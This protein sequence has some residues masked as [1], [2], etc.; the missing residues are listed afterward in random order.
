M[1]I[2]S[3]MSWWAY[4]HIWSDLDTQW[5]K[6]VVLRNM[7]TIRKIKNLVWGY[8]IDQAL[9]RQSKNWVV[10]VERRDYRGRSLRILV[11]SATLI[12]QHYKLSR[13]NIRSV[14]GGVCVCEKRLTNGRRVLADSKY[15]TMVVADF[16]Q[17]RTHPGFNLYWQV[18]QDGN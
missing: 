10:T 8:I 12:G 15:S 5:L 14:E 13:E 11:G 3:N 2:Y 1:F 18:Q 17:F 16:H 4:S 9:I 7:L 6:K